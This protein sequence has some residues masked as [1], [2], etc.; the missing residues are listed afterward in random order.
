MTDSERIE[1]TKRLK[2]VGVKDGGALV[3]G[4]APVHAF[5]EFVPEGHRPQDILPNAKSVV[6]AGNQG[7]TAGA[8]RSTDH[9]VME[10]TGYDFRENVAVHVMCDFIEREFG[11]QAIQAPSLP[12]AGHHPPMSMMLAAVLAGLGTRSLAANI[13]LHPKYGLLY[14]AALITTMEL[15]PDQRLEKNVCPDP[16]CVKLYQVSGK[17]PCMAA[18][19]ADEG[20]CL[21]GT[22]DEQGKI[23][24]SY[25]NRERCHTRAMNYGVGSFQKALTDIVCEDDAEVRK[26]KI[27]SDFFF[28][29]SSALSYYKESVAQ[30]FECMRVCP[31]GRKEKI[32][33]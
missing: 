27:Y 4:V 29:S 24:S 12:V 7:P 11:Y 28:N 25:Y 32:L 22:I 16:M 15:E 14:Y 8:W 17:T 21:D 23:A 18:C 6:V 26:S 5:N 1:A 20:G 33:K 10:I 30:C 9:R 13:I 19:P 31:I 3:V 2:D